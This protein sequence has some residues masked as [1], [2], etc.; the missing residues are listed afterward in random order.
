VSACLPTEKS[1]ESARWK[2]DSPSNRWSSNPGLP[3]QTE[4]RIKVDFDKDDRFRPNLRSV[5]ALGIGSC[6]IRGKKLIHPRPRLYSFL[7][8]LLIRRNWIRVLWRPS[9]GDLPVCRQD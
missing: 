1:V 2:S 6:L 3:N 4:H 7:P 8:M 9:L 5:L